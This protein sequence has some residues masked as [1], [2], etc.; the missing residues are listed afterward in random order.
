MF[1]FAHK[2]LGRCF[3]FNGDCAPELT[4]GAQSWLRLADIVTG[5][6]LLRESYSRLGL[7]SHE[8]LGSAD[9]FAKNLRALGLAR[10]PR[11]FVPFTTTALWF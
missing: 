9:A 7:S 2:R 6:W 4:A 5:G 10:V 8:R 1:S 3:A 11:F